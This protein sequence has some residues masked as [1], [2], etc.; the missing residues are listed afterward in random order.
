M[1]SRFQRVISSGIEKFSRDTSA[2]SA[3]LIVMM[4]VMATALFLYVLQGVSSFTIGKLEESVD[5][6]VEFKSETP[7]QDMLN[8]KQEV[9][10]LSEVSFVEYV[11]QDEALERFKETHKNDPVILETLET[12]G[13]NPLLA[14]LSIKAKDPSLYSAIV[15]FLEQR[16]YPS[17]Q[18]IDYQDRAPVIERV[19]RLISGMRTAVLALTIGL[20][21]IALLVAFNTIRLAIYNSREEIEVMRLVG[22]SNGVVQAPFIIQ[23]IVV[24][25]MANILI[26]AIA[27]P[28]AWIL[29]PRIEAFLSG[30]NVFQY[31]LSNLLIIF[32][33]QTLVGV[34]LGTLSS[35]IAIRKYLK[36]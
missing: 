25:M 23:G 8:V 9:E 6:S 7:E 1:A 15:Q 19:G 14:F 34:M 20:A 27:L 11:S 36:A 4:A 30:F 5:V 35:V 29:S 32:L 22:A 17:I 24:G 13:T 28:I 10:Q 12:I 21:L 26:L 18:R 2:S 3:A 33:I 16:A 31:L